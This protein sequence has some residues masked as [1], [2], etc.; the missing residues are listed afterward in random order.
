MD[1]AEDSEED[2][3][4]SVRDSEEDESSSTEDSDES[5]SVG[6][7][8][9]SS[10]VGDSEEDETEARVQKE[11]GEIVKAFLLLKQFIVRVKVLLN[12]VVR[13][14]ISTWS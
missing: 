9:E 7:S 4:S 13:M 6:D 3:L 14:S 5:S 10:S 11:V 12:I 1:T 8:D 2:K